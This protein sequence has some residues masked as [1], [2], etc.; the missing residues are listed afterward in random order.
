MPARTGG[1]VLARA[2]ALLAEG[3]EKLAAGIHA[4]LMQRERLGSTALGLGCA[5]PHARVD[6]LDRAMAACVRTAAPVPFDAP[7]GRGVSTFLVLLVP[8]DA[9]ETHLEMLA[10][11]AERV[12]D[13]KFRAALRD[14]SSAVEVV[15]LVDRRPS[16]PASS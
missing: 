10:A 3:D 7:D 6:A 1:E 12:A 11:A 8:H 2:A 16:R 5:V 15:S 14:C 13:P 9:D 4:A